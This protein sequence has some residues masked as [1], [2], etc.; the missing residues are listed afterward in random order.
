M[1]RMTETI[2]NYYFSSKV[3]EETFME[4]L[5]DMYLS[6]KELEAPDDLLKKQL[7]F[8]YLIAR[9]QEDYKQY[10][11]DTFYIECGEELSLGGPTYLLDERYGERKKP[12]ECIVPI[13]INL[14]KEKQEDS[15]IARMEEIKEMLEGIC[16]LEKQCID[17]V[18]DI[19]GK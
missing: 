18:I 19:L 4:M 6:S 12:Y 2:N 15:K 7:A 11:G 10:E 14:L 9:Y 3:H 8:I 17:Q 1:G 16:D 5:E 13:A